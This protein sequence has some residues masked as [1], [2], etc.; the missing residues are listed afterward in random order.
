MT[1]EWPRLLTRVLAFAG[2]IAAVWVVVGSID[3]PGWW[4]VAIWG[5]PLWNSDYFLAG[6]S[7]LIHQQKPYLIGI[8]LLFLLPTLSYSFWARFRVWVDR[9]ASAVAKVCALVLVADAF[10]LYATQADY[11]S[12]PPLVPSLFL[13]GF[14]VILLLWKVPALQVARSKGLTDDNRFERENEARKT[15]A[16]ILAGVFL[17]AG[18]Y[19]SVQ[20][21]NVS[22]D[23]QITD[24]FTK[25]IEQLGAVDEKGNPK[26]EVRLGG[27]YA[28]E[29]IARDSDR[30][31]SV[32]ME[33]LTTY[34][35]GHSPLIEGGT[36][37]QINVGHPLPPSTQRG[38]QHPD[39]DIQAILTV[40]GR[41]QQGNDVEIL[42]LR[43]TELAGADLTRANLSS[44]DFSG[45]DLRGALLYL[46]DCH[47][48]FLTEA[49]LSGASLPLANLNRAQLNGANLSGA[50]L[51]AANL[52]EANLTAAN[53]NGANLAAANLTG[54]NLHGTNL[55]GTALLQTQINFANGDSST[56][57]PTGSG[58]K[59]PNNWPR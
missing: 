14:V 51:N 39:E 24:R 25:A 6:W 18:L 31:Y 21:L 1:M 36:A 34:I 4:F 54:A 22:R 41:R 42:N 46:A 59:M 19:S 32:I 55:S 37:D 16:Q 2:F 58:L 35:R 33:I 57:L 9:W 17:F 50:I 28:L 15:L 49:D 3:D 48:G 43:K 23:G 47:T 45:A 5:Y 10:V 30:D 44:I 11:R 12:S 13:V 7:Y 26:R 29:R 8:C 56:Q 38:V 27:I 40:L 53:L 20:T 52:S